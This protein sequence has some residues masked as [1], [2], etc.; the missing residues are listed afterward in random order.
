MTVLV[1]QAEDSQRDRPPVAV[2]KGVKYMRRSQLLQGCIYVGDLVVWETPSYQWSGLVVE[3]RERMAILVLTLTSTSDLDMGWR[4]GHLSL[5]PIN[6]I[7]HL[8]DIV[9]GTEVPS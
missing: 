7:T 2:I 5:V 9:V 8:N 4:P 6:A 3:G 1:R